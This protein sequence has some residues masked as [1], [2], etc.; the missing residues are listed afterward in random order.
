MVLVVVATLR[1]RGMSS[2]SGMSKR[3]TGNGSGSNTSGSTSRNISMDSNTIG[4]TNNA[5]L[6]S[7]GSDNQ[8]TDTNTP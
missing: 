2:M 4:D 1:M 3:A 8:D 7:T 6:V 5:M